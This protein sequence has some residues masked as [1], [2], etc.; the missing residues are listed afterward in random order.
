M[1]TLP[2]ASPQASQEL[3]LR[4]VPTLLSEIGLWGVLQLAESRVM[5]GSTGTPR[6]SQALPECLAMWSSL[7]PTQLL[8]L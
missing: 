4:C 8:P 7:T 1:V 5:F 3:H 2:L 6:S